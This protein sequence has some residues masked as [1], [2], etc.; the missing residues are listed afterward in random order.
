MPVVEGTVIVAWPEAPAVAVP[1]TTTLKADA[2]N[3]PR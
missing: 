3:W 1:E 2:G